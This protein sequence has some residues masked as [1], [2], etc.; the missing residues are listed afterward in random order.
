MVHLRAL[1]A[2][3]GVALL[4]MTQAAAVGPELPLRFD[5]DPKSAG[6]RWVLTLYLEPNSVSDLRVERRLYHDGELLERYEIEPE[7]QPRRGERN[8]DAR[9]L[10]AQ[11]PLRFDG[12][13][14]LEPGL[15]AQKIIVEGRWS[16][17]EAQRP[18]HIERWS[19]FEVAEDGVRPL[20]LEEYS[21]LTDRVGFDLDAAGNRAATQGGHAREEDVELPKTESLRAI[22]LGHVG[23]LTEEQ[24][25]RARPEYGDVEQDRSEADED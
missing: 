14:G 11:L 18:L 6:E 10:E 13:R 23:G 22:P 8:Q 2:G 19:H 12:I 15:Y 21:A 1:A 20:T 9:L 3:V 16:E 7:L 24:R 4:T 25:E 5:D 17:S